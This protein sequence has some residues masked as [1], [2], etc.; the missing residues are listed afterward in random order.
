[1]CKFVALALEAEEAEGVGNDA[2]AEART[3][4]VEPALCTTTMC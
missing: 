1:M 3:V 2:V 4:L